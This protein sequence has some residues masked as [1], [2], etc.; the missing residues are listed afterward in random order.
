MSFWLPDTKLLICTW[1]GFIREE[2]PALV[3]CCILVLLYIEAFL[4]FKASLG[5]DGD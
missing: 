5:T 1:E 2:P 4:L 3:D